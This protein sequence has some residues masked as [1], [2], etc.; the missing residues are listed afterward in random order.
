MTTSTDSIESVLSTLHNPIFIK[1]NNATFEHQTFQNHILK[2]VKLTVVQDQFFNFV[3]VG[4]NEE[5]VPPS[6]QQRSSFILKS[7]G[8]LLRVEDDADCKEENGQT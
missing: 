7:N 6:V 5:N 8:F 2:I 1:C 4:N 3:K